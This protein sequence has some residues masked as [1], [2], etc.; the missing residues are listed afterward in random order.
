[1][2]TANDME[3]RG[4]S[5]TPRPPISE[6]GR[7]ERVPCAG[8]GNGTSLNNSGSNGN[9]WSS[10]PNSDNNNNSW[11]LNFNSG[12][13]NTNNNNR[14]N[15]QSVR[16]VQ[17]FA[18]GPGDAVPHRGLLADLIEAYHDARRH[19]R[20][21]PYQT[22]FEMNQERE[23][24]NLRDELLERRYT[25]RPCS[26]FIIHD[27]KMR[28]V[29]AAEFRDRVV[30]HLFYN[31]THELFER[32]FIAD[33]YSC[34]E[35][36][37]THYGVERLKHHLLS[38]SQNWTKPCYVL[39]LDVK[40]Y[41]MSIN[42]A[43]L[44]ARC[45][46]LLGCVRRGG[47][48]GA[49][50]LPGCG[51]VGTA[52][53]A[54]R[55]LDWPLVDYLLESICMLDP[56]AN[57]RI[58]GDRDEW[59]LLPK[60]KSL[61]N[62]R[63]GCGLPIG[64]LS[65]QLFSNIYLGAFDDFMKR[66]L[67]CRHYGRY[68]DDAYVVASSKEELWSIVPKARE[69]LRDELE[70]ELNEAKVRV[71]DARRGVEFLGAYVKPYRTYPANKALR[72]MRGRLKSLDW[73]EGPDKTQARVN[74]TLGVLSHYDCWHVR[75]VLTWEA[76]L[77]ERGR[78]TDDCLRFEPDRLGMLPVPH[79]V[80]VRQQGGATDER[81]DATLLAH[82]LVHDAIGADDQL[83]E[84][85]QVAWRGEKACERNPGTHGGHRL[86]EVDLLGD[87]GMPPDAV[88]VGERRDDGS[89]LLRQLSTGMVRPVN[90]HASVLSSSCFLSR[91]IRSW[92]EMNSPRSNWSREISTDRESSSRS[93]RASLSAQRSSKS[94]LSNRMEAACP[95]CVMTSG[96]CVRRVRCMQSARVWRHSV[97]DTTSLSRRG[98]CKV[99]SL[100]GIE[101]PVGETPILYSKP[102][103]HVKGDGK[104]NLKG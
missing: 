6:E 15:G 4:C 91:A 67:K 78:V 59:K 25:A 90:G 62:S 41:F 71:I 63:P 97:Y 92:C 85:V 39:K 14:N 10:V 16:P 65:S 23:L 83:T 43:R 44:L 93:R 74:S 46:E 20:G 33:S 48:R 42:R 50:A 98:R 47:G 75:K 52:P 56:V 34:I 24:V 1:M 55:E 87:L 58:I 73:S 76:R 79:G 18:A 82:D 53:R 45:R 17:E 89:D 96:R 94:D 86:K 95:F 66:E 35:G 68:V 81:E 9:Y 80:V 26:C 36:R 28:E 103:R 51:M 84:A 69:F 7:P 70:L 19:K 38:C 54:V 12:N 5:E 100:T 8:N 101:S 31:Y 13:H 49:T 60:E 40:G 2:K 27:P 29:F 21:R 64:N 22:R 102:Y 77:R 3:M 88:L 30:H 104:S 37:G 32:T 99:I 57:C 11:N 72:R 61:F